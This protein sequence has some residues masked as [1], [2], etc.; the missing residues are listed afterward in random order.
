MSTQS[1]ILED[2]LKKLS[3][4]DVE[5]QPHEDT[6]GKAEYF[7][8]LDDKFRVLL[9]ASAIRYNTHIL[10]VNEGIRTVAS[11]ETTRVSELYDSVHDRY[12]ED[13]KKSKDESLQRLKEV[14]SRDVQPSLR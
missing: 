4:P 12:K 14:L 5:W 10:N 6:S 7:T 2:L 11:F 8:N 13:L 1:D 3:K 9:S